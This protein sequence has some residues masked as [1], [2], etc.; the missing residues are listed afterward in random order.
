MLK[1]SQYERSQARR[2]IDDVLLSNVTGGVVHDALDKGVQ[3]ALLT[4]LSTFSREYVRDMNA[5]NG[6][7]LPGMFGQLHRSLPEEMVGDYFETITPFCHDA[8]A[9][10]GL[11]VQNLIQTLLG[12]RTE[13]LRPQLLE[14][15]LPY[16]FRVVLPGRGGLFVHQ[17]EQLLPYV[18]PQVG[19][20]IA[21]HIT[22]GSMM[23]W[24]ITLQCPQQGGELW[25]AD[26]TY[27]N[28]AKD[29]QH[30][31]VS[32][33]G[34]RIEAGSCPHELVRT[35][36]GSLLIFKGGTY[37]HKVI[38]PAMDSCERITL[39]GFMAMGTDGRTLHFWS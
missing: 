38:P 37:W 8:D 9:L 30:H 13:T 20:R 25:V 26:N 36:A 16:S 21:Q 22:P 29:G 31:L 10:S 3:G 27:S 34:H 7:S 19:E 33:T 23:S 14:G 32:P 11:C 35:P 5:G 4:T 15:F 17:D 24:F 6:Y 28:Y 1:F 18:Q 12:E 39:G 2:L